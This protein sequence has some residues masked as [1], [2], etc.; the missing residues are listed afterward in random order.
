[1]DNDR[2]VCEIF[3]KVFGVYQQSDKSIQKVISSMCKIVNSS[4]TDADEK[5]AALITL[6]KALF[7]KPPQMHKTLFLFKS[8]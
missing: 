7:P 3:A 2:I 4:K 5:E 1:M 8:K 6:I